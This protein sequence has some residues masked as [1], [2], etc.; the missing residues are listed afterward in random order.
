MNCP[1][2]CAEF[3]KYHVPLPYPH[4]ESV[5]PDPEYSA[6]VTGAFGGQGSEATAIAQY[7]LHRFFLD[8]YPELFT[9]YQYIAAVEIIHWRL[10]G[11]LIRALGLPP[12]LLSCET[13]AF[14]NG[15]FP[16][17]HCTLPEIIRS[18]IDGEKEAVAHYKRMT[19][20]IADE[21]IQSLFRRIILDEERHIEILNELYARYR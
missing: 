9:A 3:E 5:R 14:W 11:K 7:G 6:V 10:L 1:F 15:S 2:D 21:N 12:R 18:D 19:A 4:L 13:G 8:E 20:R 16:A 17:F